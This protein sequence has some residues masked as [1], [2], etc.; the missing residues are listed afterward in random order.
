M[1]CSKCGTPN[2]PNSAFCASCGT[3][4]TVQGG[5]IQPPP[6]APPVTG[7]AP[8][9]PAPAYTQPVSTAKRTSGMAIA[10]LVLGIISL[11]LGFTFI[12]SVLAIIFGIIAVSQ[13][14]R[15]PNLGGRGMAI[16]GIIMG[17]IGLFFGIMLVG[18][19]ACIPWD[20]QTW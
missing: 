2:A 15:D 5:V 17:I 16:A 8:M 11:G 19:L 3:P 20:M 14:G 13:T 18:I 12:P 4:L 10:S 7:Y 9:S 1:D 6:G